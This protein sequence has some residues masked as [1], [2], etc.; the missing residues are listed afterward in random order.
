MRTGC[1]SCADLL[2][3]LLSQA[4]RLLLT[5]VELPAHPANRDAHLG[6][7][8]GG[9]RFPRGGPSVHETVSFLGQKEEDC[10]GLPGQGLGTSPWP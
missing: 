5:I 2:Q 9:V 1:S 8:G 7:L 6:G 10:V 4:Q 3:L